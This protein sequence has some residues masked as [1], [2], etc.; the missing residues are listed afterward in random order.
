MLGD[1]YWAYRESCFVSGDGAWDLDRNS[2]RLVMIRRKIT[3]K[4]SAHT[5]GW[6]KSKIDLCVI[7][8]NVLAMVIVPFKMGNMLAMIMRTMGR[9]V[10]RRTATIVG[11]IFHGELSTRDVNMLNI[12]E[13]TRII[14][15]GGPNVG[16]TAT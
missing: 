11:T 3:A 4:R 9:S 5:I 15:L 14:H 6:G 10:V 8:P 7:G 16:K 1:G 12:P 2:L 13:E